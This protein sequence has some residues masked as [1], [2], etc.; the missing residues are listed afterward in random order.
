MIILNIDNVTTDF[1]EKNA[2]YINNDGSEKAW[3]LKGIHH[4][5][6]EIKNLLWKHDNLSHYKKDCEKRKNPKSSFLNRILCNEEAKY[7]QLVIKELYESCLFKSADTYIVPMFDGLMV[8]RNINKEMLVEINKWTRQEHPEYNSIKW[9][10]KPIIN[11]T[12]ISAE[13]IDEAIKNSDLYIIKKKE[14]DQ[15]HCWIHSK[16]SYFIKTIDDKY[17]EIWR[18]MTKQA[19]I[20][21]GK[22]KRCTSVA[23]KESDM[24]TEW[25][26]DPTRR[27]YKTMTF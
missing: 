26:K 11:E 12:D 19:M 4:E 7:L 2:F 16:G 23:G 15:N 10:V 22:N 5:I 1:K 18:A 21:V 27:E 3:F 13:Y 25:S 14:F 6:S 8:N 9:V 17:N 20:E 24:F